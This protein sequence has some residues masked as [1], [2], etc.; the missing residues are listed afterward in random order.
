MGS[1]KLFFIR[2]GFSIANYAS[3][4]KGIIGKIGNTFTLDPPLSDM[5]VKDLKTYRNVITKDITPDYVF[6][7]S[8][9]RAIQTAQLLFPEHVVNVAPY[10]GEHGFGLSSVPSRPSIQL[11]KLKP[12]MVKY[13]YLGKGDSLDILFSNRKQKYRTQYRQNGTIRVLYL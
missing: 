3:K 6:S 10:I 1:I 7:S 12:D 2:H 11:Q 5:G 8:L 13:L 9:L 4:K